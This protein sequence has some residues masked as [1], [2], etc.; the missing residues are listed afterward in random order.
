MSKLLHES[1]FL[2]V[3][4]KSILSNQEVL[5]DQ[6]NDNV[7]DT[8]ASTTDTTD[9]AD[10]RKELADRL[11]AN[12]KLPTDKQQKESDVRAKLF[13]DFFTTIAQGDKALLAK[14]I[15][16][17][18]PLKKSLEVLG[19]NKKTN[20]LLS[21]VCLD[22]VQEQLLK[23]GLLNVN[24]FKAIYNAVAK[25]L[26]TDSE[27][28]KVNDYNIIYCKALYKKPLKEI[29]QYL[30]LQKQVLKTSV[31]TYTPVDQAI[32]KKVFIYLPDITEPD[33]SKRA[34]IIKDL[35][36]K[37]L[38]SM[39]AT[40]IELNDYALAS[41][42]SG[43]APENVSKL[44]A[45]EQNKLAGQF[46]KVSQIFA[47]IQYLSIN[48]NSTKARSALTLEKFKQLPP[49]KILEGTIWLANKNIM[50]KVQLETTQADALTDILLGKLQNL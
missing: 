32:N 50:P 17:G 49:S 18:E 24:T 11:A 2:T 13:A 33:A 29:E 7:A 46:Q 23:P 47:A 34:K 40:G 10:W 6:D 41:A 15:L 30:E 48:T 42:I 38:P 12:K 20:A 45:E 44:S 26:I 43:K 25:R 21:F 39:R 14:L 9:I 31:E 5:G 1:T 22:Y 16:L 19:F 3:N 8:E 27:F 28:S 37:K 36:N 4:L 35:D